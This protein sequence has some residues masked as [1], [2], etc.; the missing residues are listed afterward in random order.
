MHNPVGESSRSRLH[1]V[2]ARLAVTHFGV[3]WFSNSLAPLLPVLVP[4]LGLS[5]AGAGTLTMVLQL[6]SSVAQVLFGGLADRGYAKALVVGGAVTTV[7]C[8]GM[9]G[10]E[11]SWAALVAAL[12][13]G[14]LGV[15]AF[16]PAGAM[17]AHRYSQG[18]PDPMAALVTAGTLGFAAGPIVVATV[19]D[20]F[21]VASTAWLIV[22]GLAVVGIALARLPSFAPTAS[23][24]RR[25]VRV[26]GIA[27]VPAR[28]LTLLYLLVVI[29]GFVSASVTTFVPVLLARRGA[30]VT[31]AAAGVAS[32]SPAA[33]SAGSSGD[34][35]PTTSGI[36]ASS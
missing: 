19:A 32:Y 34:R 12:V 31:L 10:P 6:S 9:L 4:R 35:W 25:G 13:C 8:L 20:R 2:V 16:H 14:G 27:S 5:L 21:G 29:R 23:R 22:P 1:P 7:I 36:G 18:H 30:S 15:A 26:R 3:D 33:G 24:P 11:R 17:L 28:P